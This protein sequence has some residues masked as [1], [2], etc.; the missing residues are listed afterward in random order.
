M[1]RILAIALALLISTGVVLPFV[2][3]SAHGLRQSVITKRHYHRRHSRA[4]WRRYRARL[5]RRREAAILAAHRRSRL[6]PIIPV[7]MLESRPNT[8]PVLVAA[9]VPLTTRVDVPVNVPLGAP[10][11]RLPSV[12]FVSQLPRVASAPV[13]ATRVAPVPARATN[14]VSISVPEPPPALAPE[15]PR[16]APASLP[17]IR[18]APVSGRATKPV[19]ITLPEP[20]PG[21]AQELPQIAPASV[22]VTRVAPVPLR[23]TKAVSAQIAMTIPPPAAAKA[24]PA[25]V[26]SSKAGPVAIAQPALSA[27]SANVPVGSAPANS[28]RSLLPTGWTKMANSKNGE[29]KF[30]TE[31]AAGVVNGVASL[32]VVAQSRPNP[33]Y[34]SAREERRLLAGIAISDLRRLVIDKMLSDGGW[35]TNDYFRDVAG[36]RVFIVS[37]QT[38][39]DGRAPDK[40]WNFYFTEVNGRIYRLTT[41]TPQEFSDRMAREAENFIASFHALSKPIATSK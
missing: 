23:I 6:V 33:I 26:A 14:P 5:K 32:D 17:A 22:P 20:P 36:Q 1:L 25:T 2:E 7:S 18:V 8:A 16:V 12:T 11:S 38:P 28:E 30:R 24:I 10:E 9:S 35:V 15:L 39:G 40:S 27:A 34:M 31:T 4:W 3:S 13:P 19:S 29:V 21:L 41:N 37:A